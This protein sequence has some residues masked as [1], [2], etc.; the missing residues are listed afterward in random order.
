MALSLSGFLLKKHHM[1]KTAVRNIVFV[2]AFA[3]FFTL[4]PHYT[5]PSESAN[6]TSVSDTLSNS[7]LSFYG[8]TEANTTGSTDVAIVATGAQ[9]VDTNQLA[10]P[11]A[12][13]TNN[14][15]IGNSIYTI[16]SVAPG[17]VGSY[18]TTNFTVTTGLDAGDAAAAQPVV[19]TQ[20]ANHTIKFTTATA[21]N[22]GKI[23]ALVKASGTAGAGLSSDGVP[24]LDGFDAGHAS[25]ALTCP[26]DVDDPAG[27]AVEYDFGT[28]AITE[29]VTFASNTYTQFDCPYTGTGKAGYSF[30]ANPLVITALINPAPKAGHTVATADT[31]SVVLQNLNASSAVV[32]QT[33]VKI[34]VIEGVRVTATVSPQ[35]S[36]LIGGISSGSV[37]TTCGTDAGGTFVTSTATTVPFGEVLISAFTY[38]AQSLTVSTNAENG[39]AVTAFQ[40]D[41][42]GVNANACADGSFPATCIPDTTGNGANIS[43]TAKG[44]WDSTT[45]K[46]FGYALHEISGGSTPAFT[47]ADTDGNCVGGTFCAKQFADIE[48]SEAAQ[49]LFTSSATSDADQVNVCYK[50][51]VSS[52]QV[53]GD[54]ENVVT[55]TATATF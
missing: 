31:Y 29:E 41:N 30:Q 40:N 20:S 49:S 24:D 43:Y 33:S 13:A 5:N 38:A 3:G 39:Y 34:A 28:P 23:R 10:D 32:D 16:E 26:T 37:N 7:R 53:A 8:I 44:R 6:L 25:I 51:V 17:Y 2:A 54:Y 55:Y 27:G 15:L 11:S 4:L 35:I 21:V 19:A 52:S 45:Y 14:V 18:D 36:F 48:N 22:G 46:G 50:I 1:M 42:L 9:S 12:G 47:R